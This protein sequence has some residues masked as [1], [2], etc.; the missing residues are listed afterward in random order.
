[1]NVSEF[2]EDTL[3]EVC[4]D[5]RIPNGSFNI[6]DKNHVY[7]LRE[8]IAERFDLEFAD[9]L[10]SKVL[11]TEGNFPERQAYNK[12][13]ILVTFPDAESKKAAI[14]RGTHLANNPGGGED[15]A[16]TSND[17]PE[18]DTGGEEGAEADVDVEEPESMF[19]D[20]EAP[21][22]M[23]SDLDSDEDT[24]EDMTGEKFPVK[25]VDSDDFDEKDINKDGEVS[26][27]ERKQFNE[28]KAHH[29]YDIL[30]S[31]E[32]SSE[33]DEEMTT[34]PEAKVLSGELHPTILFA[35]KQKWEYDKGGNW[36][37]ETGKFRA[38]TDRRGQ[39]SPAASEDKQEM[40]LWVDDYMKRHADSDMLS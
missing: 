14:D 24:G 17:A 13:G 9:A 10:I 20:Y 34:T 8:Y 36:Y 15:G 28:K 1:M 26:D 40:L 32:A 33:N 22:D 3:R 37:D 18:D 6:E 2:I 19:A 31:V 25:S 11:V 16:D 39:L 29:V 30:K 27:Q 21:E 35:L 23:Q 4:L 38:S 12:D 7:I 5:S